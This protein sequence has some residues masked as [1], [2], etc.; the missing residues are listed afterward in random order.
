MDYSLILSA[1]DE[2]GCKNTMWDLVD[3]EFD[4]YPELIVHTL[5][6]ESGFPSQIL[7]DAGSW[8]MESYT[9]TGAAQSA[10]FCFD[11]LG[12]FGLLSGYYSAGADQEFFYRW[13]GFH[14]EQIPTPTDP[15]GNPI[16]EEH[17]YQSVSL[18][19]PDLSA[20]VC[21]PDPQQTA[22]VLNAAF[23]SR[24]AA[25]EYLIVDFD[26]D[27]TDEHL[28]LITGAT[29]PFFSAVVGTSFWGDELHATYRDERISAVVVSTLADR[30]WVRT[31]R[32][33]PD[34]LVDLSVGADGITID[35]RRYVYQS[36]G[37]P[38]V[39]AP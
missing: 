21:D 6:S 4:G 31:V 24:G 25:A 7:V 16:P 22:A 29:N 23:R 10:Q 35:E 9:A 3:A 14:W 8:C 39:P 15:Y 2:M 18:R 38:F 11:E 37:I 26:G 17:F 1:L 13:S 34:A 30:T 27:G 5:A 28:F 20:Q 36:D 33:G 32:L 19:C 12:R